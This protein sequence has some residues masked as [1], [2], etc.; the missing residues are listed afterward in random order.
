MYKVTTVLYD[1][2]K[3]D[4]NKRVYGEGCFNNESLQEWH[5]VVFQNDDLSLENIVCKAKMIYDDYMV[6]ISTEPLLDNHKFPKF[7]EVMNAFSKGELKL[8][9]CGHGLVTYNADTGI[10]TI[11]DYCITHFE[12]C[13]HVCHPY[14]TS[15]ELL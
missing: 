11:T 3:P 15:I 12:I 13:P 8:A 7:K 4:R 10:N 9:P 5:P 2:N 14:K 6:E 1:L